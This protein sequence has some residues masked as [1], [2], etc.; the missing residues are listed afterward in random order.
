MKVLFFDPR[1]YKSFRSSTAPLGLLSIATYLNANGHKAAICDRSHTKES[2]NHIININK[3]DIIG[4]SVI[5]YSAVKDALNIAKC[6]KSKGIPVI[7]GG[8]ISSII[9]FEFLKSRKVDYISIGEGEETWLELAD[10]FDA[11]RPFDEIKGLAFLKNGEYIQTPERDFTDLSVLPMLDWSLIN[12][13]D[14]LQKGFAGKRQAN[15]YYSKGCFANCHFCYNKNFHRCS[16][17]QRSL[18]VV[19][20]EMDYLIENYG[21]DGFNFTDDLIFYDE[22]QVNEFVAELMKYGVHKRCGW[23]GE[24]RIDIF[25]NKD[26]FAL[27]YE[28]GC[29]NLIFGVETVSDDM[30]K[31][32]NK[33]IDPQKIKWIVNE[34]AEV[35]ITPLLTF[36]IGLPGETEEN[37]RETIE[38]AK[39][40]NKAICCFQLYTPTPGTKIYNDLV[41]AGKLNK[42]ETADEYGEIVFSEKLL[43]NI[44]EITTKEIYTIY[45]YFKLK[46]FTYKD[47]NSDDEQILK[48]IVNIVKSMTG[49]G[50]VYFFLAGINNAKNLIVL[51]SFFLHPRIRKKYGLYFTK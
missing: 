1:R 32:L 16:R 34:C 46:E 41:S 6:A 13:A 10:A 20:E 14:F 28:A 44:S 15:I 30:Q 33:K 2:L 31:V 4:V 8:T 51:L 50:I 11:G 27:L 35:G 45:R 49:K 38:F 39:S 9:P 7:F 18:K 29:R 22:N 47:K 25:K 24:I 3:P 43:K 5:T 36:M 37:I 40:L 42:M 12:P 26:I 23:I 17:R 19:I 21:V 48:V